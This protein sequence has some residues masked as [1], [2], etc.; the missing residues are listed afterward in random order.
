M[1]GCWRLHHAMFTNR[2]LLF[3]GYGNPK[4]RGC[5]LLCLL[6]VLVLIAPMAFAGGACGNS[7]SVRRHT[8]DPKLP[9][10][11]KKIDFVFT[12][13]R[14]TITPPGWDAYDGSIYHAQRGYCWLTDLSKHGRDRGANASITLQDGT[15]TSPEELGR[16]ELA[17][18]QGTHQENRPLVFRINLPNGWYGI[19]CT[20]VEPGSQHLPLVDQRSFKC[21]A[22]DVVFAGANYGPPLVVGGDRLVEGCGIVEVTESHLRI[23][24]GDPAYGGWTWKYRGLVV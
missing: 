17:N 19:T 22:H 8:L 20:S 14:R 15:R 7:I 23:V 4:H 24:V 5:F 21:R 2:R 9:S 12:G 18:W 1:K 3:R 10:F 6:S 13:D 16:L 11:D